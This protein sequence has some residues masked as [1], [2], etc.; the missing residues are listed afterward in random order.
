MKVVVVAGRVKAWRLAQV[1]RFACSTAPLQTSWYVL[2][3]LCPAWGRHQCT[4]LWSL[5][6]E[7]WK[8]LKR[9]YQKILWGKN[10]VGFTR[11]LW[12][13][14]FLGGTN[15][16]LQKW[17]TGKF[18]SKLFVC[19]PKPLLSKLWIVSWHGI[20]RRKERDVF[21][22]PSL[23]LQQSYCCGVCW[24]QL[25]VL[26]GVAYQQ[27]LQLLGCW[28]GHSLSQCSRA[29]GFEN[30][31]PPG[32]LVGGAG[33]I[34]WW[35]FSCAWACMLS[36]RAQCLGFRWNA[37]YTPA[38]EHTS[39]EQCICHGFIG[40]CFIQVPVN[41]QELCFGR[42]AQHFK[43]EAKCRRLLLFLWTS[44]HPCELL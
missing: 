8:S 5:N 17:M 11:E 24:G 4:A 42:C 15:R 32:L 33:H 13:V 10:L 6:G 39:V 21:W 36:L 30:T 34:K 40:I 2:L 1:E 38:Y 26:G 20:W 35:L 19:L 27:L 44:C 12:D 37:H 43:W 23:F 18:T 16:C 9:I 22:K 41:G 14:Y 3:P 25:P 28:L 29:S 7:S 31:E